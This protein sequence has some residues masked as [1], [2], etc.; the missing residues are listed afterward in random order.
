MSTDMIADHEDNRT[1][2]PTPDPYLKLSREELIVEIKELG[3]RLEEYEAYDGNGQEPRSE[4]NDDLS[5][6]EALEIQ[7]AGVMEEKFITLVA[8]HEAFLRKQIGFDGRDGALIEL[9]RA[10]DAWVDA[11]HA[12]GLTVRRRR[13]AE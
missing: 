5:K 11:S 10:R 4:T 13:I 12:S 9:V 7:T 2:D 8:L 1:T 3:D 6:D